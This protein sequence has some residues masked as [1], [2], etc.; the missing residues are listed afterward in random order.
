M[1]NTYTLDARFRSTSHF[2]RPLFLHGVG[3]VYCLLLS[4]LAI[5]L[6]HWS[7]NQ[8]VVVPV[9]PISYSIHSWTEENTL[10]C[11]VGCPGCRFRTTSYAIV[12]PSYLL[13]L[14]K[15]FHTYENP[16]DIT[17]ILHNMIIPK[18]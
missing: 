11:A 2:P 14:E 7:Y 17:H 6:S 15:Y 4:S 3:E 16:I 12:Y 10:L 18:I 1:G 13:P 8:L 9:L 5:S